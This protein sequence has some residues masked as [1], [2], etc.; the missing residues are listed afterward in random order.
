MEAHDNG[1]LVRLH[2]PSEY[3]KRL[4]QEIEEL[5]KQRDERMA[6]WEKREAELLGKI[7]IFESEKV[8]SNPND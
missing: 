2:A 5:R 7:R 6:Y 8:A 3:E 1:Y 4:M